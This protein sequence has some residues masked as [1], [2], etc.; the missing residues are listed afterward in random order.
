MLAVKFRWWRDRAKPIV[1]VGFV[2]YCIGFFL[3]WIFELESSWTLRW[4]GVL[5]GCVGTAACFLW[6]VDP[7]SEDRGSA[8]GES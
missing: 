2:L 5:V 3:D 4:A 8:S 6:L 1:Y 7:V